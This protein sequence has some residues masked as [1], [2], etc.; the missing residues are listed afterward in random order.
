[1]R[2][3]SRRCA[4]IRHQ[5]LQADQLQGL[6]LP[7]A[8]MIAM[9]GGGPAQLRA[10]VRHRTLLEERVH[11]VILEPSDLHWGPALAL[12]PEMNQQLACQWA[13]CRSKERHS[14]EFKWA[15]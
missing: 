10:W 7:T 5:G 15:E 9:N 13:H 12:S 8:V 3:L 1:M 2:V 6:Q 11:K 14:A 4:C